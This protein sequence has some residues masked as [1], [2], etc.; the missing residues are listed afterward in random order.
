M[1]RPLSMPGM[2]RTTGL[3]HWLIR[4][5]T[6]WRH[7]TSGMTQNPM[8]LPLSLIAGTVILALAMNT[9]A[10]LATTS[11]N[12]PFLFLQSIVLWVGFIALMTVP[13]IIYHHLVA[14][15]FHLRHWALRVRGGNLSARIPI[16]DRGEFADLAQDVNML[17]EKLQRLTRDMEEEV[18]RQ[19]QRLED[20]SRTLEVL[21]D[22]AASIN[23]SRDLEDLLIRFLYRLK[24]TLGARAA[25]VRLLTMDNQMRL[26][27]N[28]GFAPNHTHCRD[29]LP[30]GRCVCGKSIG[31][32]EMLWK[33]NVHE[34]G[35]V[36]P[37]VEAEGPAPHH[38]HIPPEEEPA[39]LAIP[40]QHQ[41]RTLGVYSL[42]LDDW[43]QNLDEDMDNLLTSIGRHL[44]MAI[45]KARLDAEAHRLTIMEE[46]THLAHELH[47]SLAQTL[48]SL[49]FRVGALE[50]KLAQIPLEANAVTS[51]PSPCVDLDPV[52]APLQL[53][54][55]VRLIKDTLTRANTE[56][57]ELISQFRAP[58]HRE[59]LLTAIEKYIQQFQETSAI[60]VFLQKEWPARSLPLEMET[61]VLRIIQESLC[62]VRKHANAQHVRVLLRGDPFGRFHVMIEDDGCGMDDEPAS[63]RP[64]EHI[65][66]NVMEER[67]ARLEGE[68]RIE[69]EPGEGTRVTLNFQYPKAQPVEFKRR[70]GTL[71]P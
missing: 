48:A 25:T 29:M 40:L 52:L 9:W 59:G 19:T 23:V 12:I 53:R 10:M 6:G 38:R 61:E 69:T 11:A 28:L 39:M 42:F 47:D 20:K 13:V 45:E 56:L 4:P 36:M 21:Y 17:T 70:F 27:A 44:G 68:L 31:N 16:P 57:R 30:V 71:N 1:K 26:V 41:G 54:S 65:G 3:A 5:A 43:P 22:V 63:G 55:E 33:A 32:G 58:V 7:K 46:R 66:L 2:R 37:E 60:Q 34:C 24:Q 8:F 18:S 51:E 62:N 67:A 49:G 15:L 35:R 64:G 14:P 50:E